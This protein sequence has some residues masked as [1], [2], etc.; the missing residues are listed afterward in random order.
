MSNKKISINKRTWQLI[1]KELKDESISDCIYRLITK[2]D[3]IN[4][5]PV[6]R[7]GPRK[8]RFHD[9]K[10]GQHCFEDY[11][12]PGTFVYSKLSSALSRWSTKTAREY[13]LVTYGSKGVKIARMK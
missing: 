7:G 8:Y 5:K 4:L 10:P 13:L 1:E 11:D 12:V 6:K 9:L 3:P 2:T